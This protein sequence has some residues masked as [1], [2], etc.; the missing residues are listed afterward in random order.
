MNKN[1]NVGVF[2]GSR[3]PEH[4]VSII[5]GQL[6][7]SELK[8][9][10]YGV[11]PVYLS[12]QGNWFIDDKLGSL[13][14]FT[15][16]EKENELKKLNSWQLEL[17]ASSGKMTFRNNSLIS[18]KI[19][20]D[21]A[22]PA[23]HG[24]NGEDGTIQGLFELTNIPY[25]GCDVLSSALAMD[26]VVTKMIYRSEGILTSEF[27][28]FNR[29]DWKN[30][31]TETIKK[32]NNLK[33]PVFIKPA[34]LGSSIGITKVKDQADLEN[35]CEVALHFDDKV[36]V[37]ESVE[38]MADI[39]CAVIGNEIAIHSL[40]QEAVF[41]G[42]HFN[43]E[44]KYLEDGGAQLG[45]AKNSLVIPA[46]LTDDKTKETQDLAVKIYKIF[47]CSGIARIDFLYEKETQKIFANEINTLP[48]TLYHHLWKKS[49][50][51]IGELLEKLIKFASEKNESKK[52]ITS[53]FNSD[54]LKFANSMKLKID[55]KQNL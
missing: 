20:I 32:I 10:G 31:K 27:I 50:I 53:V 8:K 46:N 12:K 36:I 1:L 24:V 19:T 52:K 45:N 33:W 13:K 51:E 2:F 40:I 34:R 5:T 6:I 41:S 49:G 14:F 9:L 11:T 23:F 35:A 17:S 39:T 15:N 18:K 42:D 30:D 7:I 38:N 29:T 16:L 54:L 55:K 48:G 43:Y 3:S 47:G 44:D 26:K 28:Y 25:V 4:D 21:V 37:E 22:F